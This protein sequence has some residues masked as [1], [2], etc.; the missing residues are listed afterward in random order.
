MCL[1]SEKVIITVRTA[2]NKGAL[3]VMIFKAAK[4]NSPRKYPR[5]N[6]RKRSIPQIKPGLDRGRFCRIKY[7]PG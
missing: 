2:G 4:A 5:G 3:A 7:Q 6:G 1:E